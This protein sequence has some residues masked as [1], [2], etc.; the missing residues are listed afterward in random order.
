MGQ[1]AISYIGSSIWNGLPDSIKR[2]Q[3]KH[4]QT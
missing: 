2:E 1:K 3:F 4:F